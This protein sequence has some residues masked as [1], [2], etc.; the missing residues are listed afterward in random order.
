M[1]SQAGM[2]PLSSGQP[3]LDSG[4]QERPHFLLSFLHSVTKGCVPASSPGN[5]RATPL[6]LSSEVAIT[7]P[8][9]GLWQ[10][11]AKRDPT[12]QQPGLCL[13]CS[14]CFQVRGED[15][16]VQS[17]PSGISAED[18]GPKSLRKQQHQPET[19]ADQEGFLL[20][21]SLTSLRSATI[22]F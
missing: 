22:C 3:L 13:S 18:G 9:L 17:C 5:R 8:L 14:K 20:L 7:L 4:Q 16:A 1:S 12:P 10:K 19:S 2:Q 11:Q 15:T 21:L 6:C